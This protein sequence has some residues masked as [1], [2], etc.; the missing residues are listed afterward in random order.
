MTSSKMVQTKR[1]LTQNFQKDCSCKFEN[2]EKKKQNFL[3]RRTFV[4]LSSMSSM[5]IRA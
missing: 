5:W 4:N 3:K 1:L 2:V